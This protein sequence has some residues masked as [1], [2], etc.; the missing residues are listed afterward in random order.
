MFAKDDSV[1]KR[2]LIRNKLR[3]QGRGGRVGH[4]V[5]AVAQGVECSH[6]SV[7]TRLAN[8][9]ALGHRVVGRNDGLLDVGVESLHLA[10]LV[11][12]ARGRLV[13]A[14]GKTLARSLAS[15]KRKPEGGVCS[16]RLGLKFTGAFVQA[17]RRVGRT[18]EGLGS[19]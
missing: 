2:S 9:N 1:I 14:R 15:G 4:I 12:N 6:Q 19:T 13:A 10:S 8:G 7:S 11:L 17:V 3:Q 5:H 18:A 16:G